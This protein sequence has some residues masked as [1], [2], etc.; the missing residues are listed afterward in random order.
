MDRA[1]DVSENVRPH[2]RDNPDVGRWGLVAVP[3]YAELSGPMRKDIETYFQAVNA[4]APP[5]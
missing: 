1:H 4:D 3:S 5:G 2:V